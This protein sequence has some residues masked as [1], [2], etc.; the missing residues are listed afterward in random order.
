LNPGQRDFDFRDYAIILMR[1]K[2]W[3]VLA[4][5][6]VLTS[7]GIYT[8]SQQPIYQASARI[9]IST[10]HG[11]PVGEAM[12]GSTILEA[13]DIDTQLE[14]LRSSGLLRKA[15][16]QLPQDL[17]PVHIANSDIQQVRKTN[18]IAISIRST[19]RETAAAVANALAD[20]YIARSLELNRRKT[21]QGIQYIGEQIRTAQ[22]ELDEAERALQ[23]YRE[24]TKIMA[25][26]AA[27]SAQVSK[28]RGL[29]DQLAG[30]TVELQAVEAELAQVDKQRREAEP[31]IVSETE[32]ATNPVVQQLQGKL[33]ALEMQ[34][35]ESLDQYAEGSRK[36]K[37]LDAQ[38]SAFKQR[39]EL[40]VERI[41]TGE[42]EAANPVIEQL[43]KRKSTLEAQCIALRAKRAALS[44]T[45]PSEMAKLV[46]LPAEQVEFTRLARRANVAEDSYVA[47]LQKQQE[48][49]IAQGSEVANAAVAGFAAVPT[50]PVSPKVEQN[51][52]I[53]AILG[54]IFGLVIA[55][56]VDYLDD[57]IKD[58]K[59][60]ENLLDLPVIGL[61]AYATDETPDLA[62]N[63]KS[64]S[65]LAEAFR[66]LRANIRFS[67]TDRPLKTLL[68]TS[69]GPSEGKS[70][71]VADLAIAVANAGQ[72]VIAVDTDL[73]R[74]ALH[75]FFNVENDVGLTSVLIGE[76]SL[77]EVLVDTGESGVTLLTSGAI[78]PN[79]IEFIESDA[80]REL[81]EALKERADVVIF[82][83]P[84]LLLVADAQI[85]SSIADGTLL[86]VEMKR[87]RREMARQ[88]KELLVRAGARILGLAANKLR[89]A[90]GGYY[91]Y[92]YYYYYGGR[93]EEPTPSP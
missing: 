50:M 12:M 21:K 52:W 25:A 60:A 51:L 69:P 53:A 49:L 40:E 72:K 13:Q 6:A 5:I 43:D 45:L 15:M 29:E 56:V 47:L 92:Y 24:N 4:F 89:R 87:T 65:H 11:T 10:K 20:T 68:V 85:L 41:V 28:V 79:P 30:L 58:P 77:D 19:D 31:T 33:L 76:R 35:V 70:T 82:D 2:W 93:D 54:L 90:G 91:Y 57:S 3:V 44:P 78:P 71:I 26:D 48:L 14:I 55:V 83:S 84:P 75:R 63:P 64:R 61:I 36:I 22:Q 27:V 66:T 8:L 81:I 46:S 62:D 1:R 34:R 17:K 80:M 86:V 42:I 38:I 37:Q 16:D 73:R 32:K 74:P 23:F 7:T 59:E 88:G 9:L 67:A 18:I 39:L